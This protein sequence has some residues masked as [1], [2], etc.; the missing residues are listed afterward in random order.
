MVPFFVGR[1]LQL[2]DLVAAI[3]SAEAGRGIAGR[4][5]AAATHVISQQTGA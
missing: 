5:R 4:L 2:D 1:R 3:A